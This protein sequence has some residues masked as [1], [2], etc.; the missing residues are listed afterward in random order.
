MQT[1]ATTLKAER[2]KIRKQSPSWEETAASK[3]GELAQEKPFL[4]Q[5]E[6]LLKNLFSANMPEKHWADRTSHFIE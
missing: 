2:K 5:D 1:E 3:Q 4:Y 6:I